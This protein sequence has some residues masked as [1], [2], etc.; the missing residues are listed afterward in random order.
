VFT[1][2]AQTDSL[3]I[4]LKDGSVSK[5]SVSDIKI[6][7]FENLTGVED[8]TILSNDLTLKGNYPN[9][10]NQQTNIEFELASSGSVEIMIYDNAGN[11]IQKLDCKDCKFGKN[12]VQWNCL[13]N[14]NN[15]VQNGVYFYEV[16][17]NN[18]VQSKKMIMVK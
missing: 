11:Q 17:F 9:P 1:S 5:I 10:F 12:S 7:Q 3:L 16:R 2:Y 14:N 13:D 4:K 8:Q 6:I 15:K 18:E